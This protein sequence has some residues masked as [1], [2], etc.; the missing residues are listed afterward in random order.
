MVKQSQQLRRWQREAFQ[1]WRANDHRGIVKVATGAGKTYFGLY[2]ADYLRETIANLRINILVPTIALLDQW[3]SELLAHEAF[4]EQDLCVHGGGADDAPPT[5]VNIAVIN[6]ARTKARKMAIGAPTLLVVDECHRAASPANASALAGPHAATLGLS[7][8]PERQ[9]DDYFDQVLLPSVGP[10]IYDYSLSDAQVDQIVVPVRYTNVAIAM[11]NDEEAVDLA[12]SRRIRI[13]SEQVAT[14]EPLGKE[15]EAAIFRRA[16][17]RKSAS[18]R[19]PTAVKLI[20][21][22]NFRRCL[23]FHESIEAADRIVSIL[24]QRGH[25]AT[26]YHTGQSPA[27]RADNLRRFRNGEY[28]ILVACR[29]LDEGIDV[30]STDVAI[31]ASASKST[32][33][34]IQRIGRVLRRAPDKL[35]AQVYT[36]YLAGVEDGQLVSEMQELEDSSEVRWLEVETNAVLDR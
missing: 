22:A 16:A 24:K 18:M 21:N 5:S 9:H 25:R 6:T 28:E 23:V 33:Q 34:R 26:A 15:L 20:E 29:S 14:G 36:V 2:C 27:M 30:P 3:H 19:I 32:R 35:Y 8:T 1:A 12:Q 31:I 13:L 10:V 7:A 17:H 4:N 11:T